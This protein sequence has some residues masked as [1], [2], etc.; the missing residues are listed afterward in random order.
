MLLSRSALSWKLG[1]DCFFSVTVEEPPSAP[2]G[3]DVQMGEGQLVVTFI[4]QGRQVP[5]PQVAVAEFVQLQRQQ[6]WEARRRQQR[7]AARP[8]EALLEGS[9]EGGSRGQRTTE[10]DSGAATLS[11]VM[12]QVPWGGDACRGGGGRPP[13][14]LLR[15]HIQPSAFCN[16]MSRCPVQRQNLP[17]CL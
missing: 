7:E 1:V 6:K 13:D 4:V 16:A 2:G 3:T 8:A 9:Q 14:A 5:P 11:D 15:N 10:P 17:I 12:M